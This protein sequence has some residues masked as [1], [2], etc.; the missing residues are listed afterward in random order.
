MQ[1]F[2]SG[3]SLSYGAVNCIV[4]F[5]K[6][7]DISSFSSLGPA[8]DGSRKPWIAAP[9]Q[10]IL[11]P[12]N[13]G[14]TTYSYASGTSFAA[15]HVAGT[16]AL[17]LEANPGLTPAN[18]LDALRESARLPDGVSVWD[19][20]WGWGKIDAYGAVEQVA[21]EIPPP[22]PPEPR[23][24]GEGDDICFIAT[25]AFGDVDAPQVVRLREMRD[26]SILKTS[27]G[28]R[29]V[30]F[31]YRW[32]PPVAAW[33]KEHTMTSRMVRLLLMPLAGISEVA[34]HRGSVESV[35]FSSLGLFL[36]G[37]VC[38]FS[39]KRRTR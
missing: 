8:R 31:Y 25:A 21:S 7:G 36:L 33:L 23:G 30:R 28:R 15:P 3:C 24:L 4:G 6:T 19:E 11:T 12:D 34:Y 5:E 17:M 22:P 39:W 27:L 2:C 35:V 14:D 38:Y 13:Q 9:G 10:A 16:V 18:V 1:G 29:F 32:S 26:K 37:T 20:G